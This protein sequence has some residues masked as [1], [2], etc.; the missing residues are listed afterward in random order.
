MIGTMLRLRPF[1]NC[2]AETVVSWIKAEND[3]VLLSVRTASEQ[4]F[5][6][7]VTVQISTGG[8]YEDQ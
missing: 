3:P 7:S 8:V 4:I 6:M 5:G 2:D 1:K